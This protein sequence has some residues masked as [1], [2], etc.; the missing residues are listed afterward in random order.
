L[1]NGEIE[2]EFCS[3]FAFLPHLVAIRRNSADA[4]V[5]QAFGD[6]PRETPNVENRRTVALGQVWSA[7]WEAGGGLP[8]NRKRRCSSA[9]QSTG[10][11]RLA[12]LLTATQAPTT[13]AEYC[14]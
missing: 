3:D 8:M 10:C 7:D 1:L 9:F 6:Q 13:M 14:Q 5:L 12:V 4:L 2:G 11:Q